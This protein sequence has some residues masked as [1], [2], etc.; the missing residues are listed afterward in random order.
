MKILSLD[1][2]KQSGTSQYLN[3][4]IVYE[5]LSYPEIYFKIDELITTVKYDHVVCENFFITAQ[6]AKKSVGLAWSLRIIGVCDYICQ[7]EGVEMILQSPSDAKNFAT[8]KKLKDF[9]MWFPDKE[10]H[11]RDS[12]RH[13]A[14][15]LVRNYPKEI[16][17]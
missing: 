5:Q 10:G 15:F 13:L 8:D 4:E 17:P 11:C 9:S 14:L 12:L 3:G 6:T 2:G 7:R 1:P 16:L